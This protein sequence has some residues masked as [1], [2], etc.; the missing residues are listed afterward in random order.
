LDGSEKLWKLLNARKVFGKKA[1]EKV[2]G[3][4]QPA[5]H[6]RK[7]LERQFTAEKAEQ[8][9]HRKKIHR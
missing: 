8:I 2:L 9:F 6:G 3:K 5:F 1:L 4:L 7:N